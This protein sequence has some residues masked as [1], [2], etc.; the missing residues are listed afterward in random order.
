MQNAA[1]SIYVD[2]LVREYIVGLTDA[3]RRHADVG[4]WGVAP[5]FLGAVPFGAGPWRWCR[6]GTMC[7]PTTFRTW[8]T[9]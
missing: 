4:S 9:E 1:K 7:C 8:P 2:G 5:G 3:T 6:T